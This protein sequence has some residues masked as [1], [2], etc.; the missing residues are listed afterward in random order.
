MVF[1]N[2]LQEWLQCIGLVEYYDVLA[3]DGYEDMERVLDI[4]WEDLEDIGIR[5]LGSC[6][7][8]C[9]SVWLPWK[10]ETR[11]DGILKNTF[12]DNRRLLSEK[13]LLLLQ[14]GR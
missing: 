14:F 2:T 12:S 1:Q 11:F 13:L 10:T 7:S 9:L 8:V 3:R 5:K 6:L 4:I